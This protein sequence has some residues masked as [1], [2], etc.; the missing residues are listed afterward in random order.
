MREHVVE[1]NKDYKLDDE[2]EQTIY[3]R[4]MPDK[5]LG[6]MRRLLNTGKYNSD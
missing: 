5:C 4:I 3:M 1:E 2:V 6:E